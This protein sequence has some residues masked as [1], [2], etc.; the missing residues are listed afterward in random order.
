MQIVDDLSSRVA[1]GF[2]P[3][4]RHRKLFFKPGN[5]PELEVKPMHD[6]SELERLFSIPEACRILGFERSALY[7]RIK[8]GS[9]KAVKLDGRVKIPRAE[10]AK[11]LATATPMSA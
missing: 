6:D 11:Y 2:P 3:A 9:L 7:T 10:L 1:H 5:R 8:A 4:D